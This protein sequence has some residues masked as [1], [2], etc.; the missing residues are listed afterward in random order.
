ME[1]DK[2]PIKFFATREVDELRIEGNRNTEK[3]KWVLRGEE[4][5]NRADYLKLAL[6][7]IEDDMRKRKD[8]PVPFS[9]I[10]RLQEDATAKSKRKD[11]SNF[12]QPKKIGGVIGLTATNKLIV[13]FDSLDEFKEISDRLKNYE[14]NDYAISC[15][16]D[17]EEYVPSVA[18]DRKSVV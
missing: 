15:I 8:S 16:E 2:L 3:P 1:K 5:K 10:A 9:F 12:F 13:S 4:L 6:D 14:S 18:I 17:F 7:D 11:I